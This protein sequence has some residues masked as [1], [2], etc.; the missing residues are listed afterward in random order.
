[1]NKIT[2]IFGIICL[3]LIVLYWRQC[4]PSTL[5]YPTKSD[6]TVDAIV[7][8]AISDS[9]KLNH[10]IDSLQNDYVLLEIQNDSLTSEINT[11]KADLHTKGGYILSLIDQYNK[12]KNGKDSGLA[13]TNCDSLIDEVLQ[14]KGMVT[15]YE[16]QNDSL[17]KLTAKIIANKDTVIRRLSTA[18]NEADAQ[19]FEVSRTYGNMSADYKKVLKQSGKKWGFGP[20]AGL[21]IAGN[22]VAPFFGIGVSY[23]LIKF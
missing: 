12:A 8:K 2:F 19:L 14:A 22:G 18:F 16:N 6:S 15:V 23:N 11:T 13:L 4:H 10:V 5:V 1:M 20:V 7:N 17:G 9:I 3:V 21:G